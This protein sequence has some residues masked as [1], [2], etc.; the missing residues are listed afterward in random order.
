MGWIRQTDG[1]T[2]SKLIVPSDETGKGLI[3]AKNTVKL[4]DYM[5]LN[6]VL[7]DCQFDPDYTYVY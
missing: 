1:Q 7:F 3:K 6:Y 5:S 2:E 4:C